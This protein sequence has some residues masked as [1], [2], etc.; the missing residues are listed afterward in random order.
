MSKT[1]QDTTVLASFERYGEEELRIAISHFRG[2]T[3]LDLRIWY[4]PEDGG[5]YKP[6]KRGITLRADEIETTIQALQRAQIELNPVVE[7]QA[8]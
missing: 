4:P 8:T 2:R 1:T 6:T 5:E 7:E 3:L